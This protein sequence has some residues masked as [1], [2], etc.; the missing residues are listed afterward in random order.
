MFLGVVMANNAVARSH[1][2]GAFVFAILM[3]FVAL[4][5]GLRVARC[6]VLVEDG[7]VRVVNPVS[8]VRMKWSEIARFEFRTYG[9][10]AIKRVDGRSVS[11]VGIQQ[12]AWAARRGQTDTQAAEQIAA[13]N[14]LLE[15]HRNVDAPG[16]NVST[17]SRDR[18]MRSSRR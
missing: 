7:G 11:I 3:V 1:N 18:R 9:S 17:R 15:A 16:S 4:W 14:A 10:C 5:L 12:S 13:L 8:T 2:T 6:G